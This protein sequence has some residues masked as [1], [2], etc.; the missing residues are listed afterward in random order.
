MRNFYHVVMMHTSLITSIANQSQELPEM[1]R[2]NS[3]LRGLLFIVTNMQ[4]R[5]LLL[6]S[7]ED[8]GL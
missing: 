4:I 6:G 8:A 3:T 7:N 1:L 2:L 5:R